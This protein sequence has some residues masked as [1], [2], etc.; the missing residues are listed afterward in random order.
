[1]FQK[2]E[3]PKFKLFL[4]GKTKNPIPENRR[5]FAVFREHLPLKYLKPDE[6]NLQPYN[7][8]LQMFF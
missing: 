7:F 4:S 8:V 1:M 6:P 3:D 2:A 5:F